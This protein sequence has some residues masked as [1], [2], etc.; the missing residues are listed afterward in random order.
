LERVRQLTDAPGG[1][2]YRALLPATRPAGDY[3]A[4]LIPAYTGVAVPLE[5]T[6]ILWQR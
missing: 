4:R 6:C 2:A 3:T 1:Y 5:A